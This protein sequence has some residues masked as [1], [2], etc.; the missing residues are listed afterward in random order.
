VRPFLAPK[1]VAAAAASSVLEL[2]GPAVAAAAAA[3][4]VAAAVAVAAV[5]VAEVAPFSFGDCSRY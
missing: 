2:V 5:A 3:A 4:V 1:L